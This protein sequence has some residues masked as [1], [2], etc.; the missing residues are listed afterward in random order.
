MTWWR[1]DSPGRAGFE[2]GG[3]GHGP[4]SSGSLEAGK[5]TGAVSPRASAWNS[6]LLT[7]W[8]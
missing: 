1:E 2:D 6:A 4:R 8:L 5:G 3:S 7:P